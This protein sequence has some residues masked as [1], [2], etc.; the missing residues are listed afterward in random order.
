MQVQDTNSVLFD[1]DSNTCSTII[2]LETLFDSKE[3]VDDD[4]KTYRL[5]NTSFIMN[6]SYN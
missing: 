5:D 2:N 3:S 6:A 1:T 4:T